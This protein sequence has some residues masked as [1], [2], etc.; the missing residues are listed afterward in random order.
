MSHCPAEHRRRT[1]QES[2][3]K[4]H[5]HHNLGSVGVV[6][7]TFG[8][9]SS[10]RC[11]KNNRVVLTQPTNRCLRFFSFF[12]SRFLRECVFFLFC[13]SL[14]THTGGLTGL[15]VQPTSVQPDTHLRGNR[16]CQRCVSCWN[17][18]QFPRQA[19]TGLWLKTAGRKWV[20]LRTVMSP[21][22]Y[23]LTR[24]ARSHC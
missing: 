15:T 12:L 6:V 13:L 2:S 23:S 1:W 9:S 20:S 21:A 17:P 24:D 5:T 3:I 8:S 16:K 19:G 22:S 7:V 18:G 11:Y 14:V 10:C 4:K